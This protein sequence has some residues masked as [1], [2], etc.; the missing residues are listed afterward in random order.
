MSR[1]Y[2][3]CDGLD[4]FS[5]VPVSPYLSYRE[6]SAAAYCLAARRIIGFA[7]NHS[8]IT[9]FGRTVFDYLFLRVAINF[10]SLLPELLYCFQKCSGAQIAS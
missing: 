1:H 2:L 6:P 8:Q 5:E 9:V 7:H 10:H 3:S 4:W